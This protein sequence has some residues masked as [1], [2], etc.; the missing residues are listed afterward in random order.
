[1]RRKHALH[2]AQVGHLGE[3]LRQL[4]ATLS[5]QVVVRDAA[6][7]GKAD[8]QSKQDKCRQACIQRFQMGHLLD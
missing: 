1:M 3:G 6:K 7:H 2:F 5:H 8:A 4:H